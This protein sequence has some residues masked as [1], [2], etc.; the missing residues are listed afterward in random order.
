M[1]FHI[2]GFNL[3][4]NSSRF[5]QSIHHTKEKR[6]NALVLY[7]CIIGSRNDHF[8]R[9]NYAKQIYNTAISSIV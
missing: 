3:P 9:N 6:I 2:I 7:I 4:F 5:V 1:I 8:F